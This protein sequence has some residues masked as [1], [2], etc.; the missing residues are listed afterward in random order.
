MTYD[1][2][3]EQAKE[4]EAKKER[5]EKLTQEESRALNM[6]KGMIKPGEVRNP[7]GRGK[8]T[9]NWSTRIK[10]L[11]G[12]EKFLKTVIKELPETWQGIVDETPADVI[13][14]AMIA[15]VARD[16]S[17]AV[18]QG[19]PLSEQTLKAIDRLGKLGYGDKV[20]ID[21]EED[22]F[23]DKVTLNFEVVPDRKREN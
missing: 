10:R 1:E 22:G 12:D 19:K 21:S 18:A 20:V 6:S 3:Q 9:I 7:K 2:R 4:L 5:G 14:A 23:F 11:M 15:C 17:I 16:A 13:A 8:G